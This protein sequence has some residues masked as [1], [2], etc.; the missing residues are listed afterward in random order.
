MKLKRMSIFD[1]TKNVAEISS[2]HVFD[3]VWQVQMELEKGARQEVEQQQ[4]RRY[5]QF[6]I[7]N[8]EN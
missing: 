7:A 8:I 6:Q 1:G 4:Y 3:T 2:L 5:V